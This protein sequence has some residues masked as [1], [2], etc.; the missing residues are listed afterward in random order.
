LQLTPQQPRQSEFFK[1][2]IDSNQAPHH[3]SI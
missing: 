1:M 2:W 3:G